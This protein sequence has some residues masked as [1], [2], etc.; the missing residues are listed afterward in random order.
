MYLIYGPSPKEILNKYTLLTGRP[1]LVPSWTF[2]LWLSTSFT[3]NYDEK[4]VDAFLDGMKKRDIPTG[5]FH[6]DCFWM[7]GFHWCDFEFDPE[8]FPNP[9]AQLTSLKKRGIQVCRYLS[10]SLRNVIFRRILI[11]ARVGLCMDK[12]IYCAGEQNL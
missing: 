2:G 3:T 4:T 1:A 11:S 8:Y 6:Y 5:V 9:K 7:R 12:F 10:W